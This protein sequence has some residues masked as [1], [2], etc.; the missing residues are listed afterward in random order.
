MVL[1]KKLR[2][3]FFLRKFK[4]AYHNLFLVQKFQES[5]QPLTIEDYKSYIKDYYS[6]PNVDESCNN[7]VSSFDILGVKNEN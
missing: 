7:H 1:I 6:T 2:N 4:K 3:Y 5:F